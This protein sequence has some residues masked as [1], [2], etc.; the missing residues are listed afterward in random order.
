M[1]VEIVETHCSASLFLFLKIGISEN[2]IIFY[3]SA[4]EF[5]GDVACT[6]ST[7]RCEYF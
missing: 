7:D 4:A 5:L 2:P 1:K 6:V 3:V